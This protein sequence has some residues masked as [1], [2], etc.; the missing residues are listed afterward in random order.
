MVR[1]FA[2]HNWIESLVFRLES[3]ATRLRLGPW[4]LRL[5][6]PFWFLLFVWWFTSNYGPWPPQFYPRPSDVLSSF[7]E[8]IYKGILPVHIIES[9]RKLLVAGVIALAIAIPLG[10]LIS[11]SKTIS[12]MLIPFINFFQS[13]TEI[14]WL[15]LVILFYGRSFTS[16]TIVICYTIFFPVLF[17]T[18]LGVRQVSIR[19]VQM[20][21]TLGANGVQI[22][23]NVVFP[24]SLPSI[25]SGIRSGMSYGWRALI[26]SEMIA[27]SQGLG[28]LI[29]DARRG[30]LTSRII[31][32]MIMIGI[33]WILMD[34]LFLKPLE[35]STIE[36]WGLV[37][38]AGEG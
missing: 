15:P 36:H 13:I 33:G 10:I 31:V 7:Y 28:Y 37:T 12:D 1:E 34:R 20:L 14:A 8:L 25:V 26:A 6:G 38:K 32:G 4:F 22:I 23:W 30:L 17:N 3:I 29:F 24:G 21:R 16:M 9:L 2:K 5:G 35:E 19:L 11:L 18:V 27:G